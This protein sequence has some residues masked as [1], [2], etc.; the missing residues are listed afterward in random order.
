ML[1]EVAKSL[2]QTAEDAEN[3]A[4]ISAEATEKSRQLVEQYTTAVIR[5]G[6]N[7]QVAEAAA[8]SA[9]AAKLDVENNRLAAETA[10]GDTAVA[11]ASAE[12]NLKA[13]ISACASH[14]RNNTPSASKPRQKKTSPK[15]Q[16]QDYEEPSEE[17]DD[18]EKIKRDLHREQDRLRD[19]YNIR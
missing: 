6:N 3:R 11:A 10:A 8:K 5:A 18:L 15:T 9:A 2:K 19:T 7:K 4:V 1:G 16:N 17:S 13:I 14:S 12:K